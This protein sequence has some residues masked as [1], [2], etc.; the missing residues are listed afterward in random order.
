MRRAQ[1]VFFVCLFSLIGLDLSPAVAQDSWSDVGPG[2]RLLRR[3]TSRPWRIFAVKADLCTTGLQV[4]ATAQSQRW[5]TVPAFG[6]LVG[7]AVAIN[8]DF[9]SYESRDPTGLALSGGQTWHADMNGAGEILF[10]DDRAELRLPGP[11]EPL[12]FWAR[13]GVSGRPTIVQNG[14]VPSSFNRGDCSARHPRTAIGLSADQ[15]TLIMAVV[16]GRSSISVGMT[17]AELG[18]LMKELGAHTAMN[19]DGGGSSTLW[20]RS[21]G[22]INRPSDGNPRTVSNHLALI[23]GSGPPGH[24]DFSH[25]EVLEQS[26]LLDEPIHTDVNGDGRPDV[27][28]RD[29]EGFVCYL[30]KPPDQPAGF[31]GTWRI[32]STTDSLGWNDPD[33]FSTLRIGDVN[34]DGMADLCARANAGMRCWLST[35]SGFASAF[36]GPELSDAAGF[37]D[38][39]QGSTVRLADLDGDG[40]A[41]ICYRDREGVACH[42][43]R[44][45]SFGPAFRGPTL[46]DASGWRP[47]YHSG[48]IRMGDLDGDGKADLC[49][50]A[51]VGLVCWLS[52]G[53]SF[54]PQ[55]RGPAWSND[56][57]FKEVAHWST[58]RM[59]DLD[60]DGA[61]EVCARTAEGIECVRFVNGAFSAPILGPRLTNDSGWADHDNYGTIRY[62]DV[63]GDGDTDI[64]ARANARV[65]CWMNDDM[66]FSRRIEGPEWSD[67][68]GWGHYI[69][70]T[71][72]NFADL[73]GDG[74]ADICA[75]AARGYLCYLSNGA[76]FGSGLPALPFSNDDGFA[77]MKYRSVIRV[78]SP[79]PNIVLP[80]PPLPDAGPPDAAP[81]EDAGP[82]EDADLFERDAQGDDQPDTEPPI[83]HADA[84]PPAAQPDAY[85]PTL[86]TDAGRVDHG[87]GEPPGPG[88]DRGLDEPERWTPLD[89]S[90]YEDR[91]RETE[92]AAQIVGGC[93]STPG[94]APHTPLGALC[95]LL[96]LGGLWRRA[97]RAS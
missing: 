76:G 69:Y 97:R 3:S 5:R 86:P 2:L 57:G 85:W 59:V 31:A 77:A 27:C 64:C 9:F 7:A 88:A 68:S 38:A 92:R 26:A 21:G 81:P 1:A 25:A 20:T 58:I 4:K 40:K 32:S 63:D 13:E 56:N 52:R 65:F 50:R 53:D 91:L 34:G 36:V 55:I 83:A 66:R 47:L 39:T 45:N 23:S 61:D 75:R 16:D 33:N 72:I 95:A 19:L 24:C 49:A 44:G 6:Q 41:D 17:C 18:N 71:T 70:N 54:G 35:G 74:K 22:V 62:A 87:W 84:E 10:G 43:S 12:P 94:T 37:N 82:P 8:A 28:A 46:S 73:N 48:T 80:D 67:D 30:S 60:G 51:A 78:A 96:A 14:A 29:A 11:V 79:Q 90:D 15:R 42:L 89:A 93:Q